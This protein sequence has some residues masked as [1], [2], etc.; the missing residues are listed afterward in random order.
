MLFDIQVGDIYA[1]RNALLRFLQAKKKDDPT[2]TVI[3]VG[4]SA[5]GWSHPV[6]DWIVDVNPVDTTNCF[7][8]NLNRHD[9]WQN[10]LD[11]VAEHGKFSFAICSHTLE[12]I[13]NPMLVMEMLPKIAEEGHIAVPSKYRELANVESHNFRGYMH[14]RW[15]YNIR[16]EEPNL[17][18]GFPKLSFIERYTRL[19]SLANTSDSVAELK[20]RWKGRIPYRIINDDYLGPTSD[21]VYDYYLALL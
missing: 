6:A 5:G 1:H 17:F 21:A 2:F 10:V 4:G 14:H 8:V 16:P 9:D 13:A 19:H 7:K 12:D 11:Y 15:I 3:D 20:F 18:V